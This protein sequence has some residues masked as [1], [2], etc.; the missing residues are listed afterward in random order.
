MRKL[1]FML[2]LAGW[3]IVWLAQLETTHCATA[4]MPH[5]CPTHL[6]MSIIKM[7]VLNLC[8]TLCKHIQ[9]HTHTYTPKYIHCVAFSPSLAQCRLCQEFWWVAYTSYTSIY[10]NGIV[11]CFFFFCIQAKVFQR[12]I[13]CR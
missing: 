11:C 8:G 6:F 2:L 9:A 3:M 7:S 5:H 13:Q 12:A 1:N 10:I 4:V